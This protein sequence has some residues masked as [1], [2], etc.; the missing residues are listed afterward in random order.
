[1]ARHMTLDQST[2]IYSRSRR[3]FLTLVWGLSQV[4]ASNLAGALYLKLAI[5]FGWD[6]SPYITFVV[7]PL[8]AMLAWL[9]LYLTFLY[10]LGRSLGMERSSIFPSIYNPPLKSQ[11][12]GIF[13]AS[14]A[15]V[16]YM[17]SLSAIGIKDHHG[18]LIIVLFTGLFGAMWV[19][20]L[21]TTIWARTGD[22]QP[23]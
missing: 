3:V 10:A 2:Y 4:A 23:G 20:P 6:V 12:A 21:I 13:L 7:T 19:W 17:G 15:M 22:A 14:F 18:A 8:L 5:Y 1:M 16:I 9:L 11:Y